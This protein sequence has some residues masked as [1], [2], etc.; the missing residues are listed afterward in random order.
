MADYKGAGRARDKNAKHE[1]RPDV[2]Q[3]VAGP[4]DEARPDAADQ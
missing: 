3:H 4:G 2:R 1:S